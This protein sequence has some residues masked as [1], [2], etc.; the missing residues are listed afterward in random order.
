VKADAG[1]ARPPAHLGSA[2]RD[3]WVKTLAEFTIEDAAGL[4]LLQSACEAR[5]RI[6][7]AR[8]AIEEHGVVVRDR[9]GELRP[10][11]GCQ[12]EHQARGAMARAL[13]ALRLAPEGDG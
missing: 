5:D 7:A 2:G 3:L 12:I 9:F 11:P 13:S 8:V 1:K 10:H 6:E 4:A